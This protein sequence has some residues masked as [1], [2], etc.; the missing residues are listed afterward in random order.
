MFTF[1]MPPFTYEAE[2]DGDGFSVNGIEDEASV[3]ADVARNWLNYTYNT[4]RGSIYMPSAEWVEYEVA[5]ALGEKA[6]EPST[7]YDEAFIY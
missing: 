2:F 6:D 1:Q 3:N 5:K 4:L 7:E